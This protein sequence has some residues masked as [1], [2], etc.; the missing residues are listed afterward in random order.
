MLDLPKIS[1]VIPSFNQ[2]EFIERTIRSIVDQSYPS[3]ELILMD[4]GSTDNTMEIVERYRRHFYHIESGPDGGQ[5]SALRKGFELATGDFVSW[6][7]S[8]D[9]YEPGALLIVGQHL[10]AHPELDFV[11]GDVNYIDSED[12]LIANKRSIPYTRGIVR[13]AFLTFPQMSAFWRRTIHNAVG[14]IDPDLR[15]CMDYDLFVRLS[16]AT[17][18]KLIKHT[19]GNFRLHGASKTTN[20]DIIRQQ[21]DN[22]VRRRYCR[23]KPNSPVFRIVRLFWIGITIISMTKNG[24]LK[25]RLISK[26]K[27]RL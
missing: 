7:N 1:I 11:Y 3:L 13:Y 19:I 23:V 26:M 16:D 20:L 24:G 9:T 8:D 10:R 27:L 4:G 5:S 21:E 17:N 15:F 25:E 14:G 18:P 12:R 2:G 6:L 22:L